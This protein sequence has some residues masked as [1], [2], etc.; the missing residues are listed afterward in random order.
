MV[1]G[2]NMEKK[3]RPELTLVILLMTVF[4]LEAIEFTVYCPGKKLKWDDARQYCKE[5]YI[6]MVS[7]EMVN[8]VNFI[9][10]LEGNHFLPVWVGLHKDP[11]EPL[12]WKWID[13]K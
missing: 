10:W 5:N 4:C 7:S 12:A 9:D 3:N 1:F 8:L 11:E 2:L 13:V 6:D